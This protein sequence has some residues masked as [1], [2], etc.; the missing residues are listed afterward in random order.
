M[1]FLPD[2]S[3]YSLLQRY[4]IKHCVYCKFSSYFVLIFRGLCTFITDFSWPVYIYHWFFLA[5]VHL[6]LIF[7][8]L[9]TFIIDFSWPVYI[10]HWFFLTCAHLSLIFPSLC[11][12]IINF[13]RPFYIYKYLWNTISAINSQFTRIKAVHYTII[14]LNECMLTLFLEV[15]KWIGCYGRH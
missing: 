9:C 1:N 2:R 13:L 4:C 11:T 14:P 10:Y 12:F 5:C 3:L 15:Y 6:S 8:G 7:P